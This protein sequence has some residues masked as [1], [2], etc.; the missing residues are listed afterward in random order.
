ME[1]GRQAAAGDRRAYRT[2]ALA[3]NL[4]ARP[5]VLFHPAL[6]VNAARAAVRGRGAPAPRPEVLE[7]L[8]EAQAA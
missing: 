3:Y 6:F 4:M 1:L 2:F 8:R 7:V 5:L